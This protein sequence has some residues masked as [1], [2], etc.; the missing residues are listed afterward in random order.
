MKPK[1]LIFCLI[2]A[3]T[4]FSCGIE[5]PKRNVAIANIPEVID[6][7]KYVYGESETIRIERGVK[8]AASLWFSSDGTEEDFLKFCLKQFVPS[9]NDLDQLFN[10]VEKQFESINGHMREMSIQL[11][12]PVVTRQRKITEIDRLFGSSSPEFD[13]YKNKLAFAIALNFPHYTPEEKENY[14]KEW[15]RKEWAMARIGDKFDSRLNP[16]DAVDPLPLPDDLKDYTGLYILSMDHILSPGMEVLFPEGTRLNCHHGLRDEIKGLYTRED[17]LERQRMI[18]Q[19]VMHILDQTIPLCMIGETEFFWKPDSNEVFRKEGGKYVK[20]TFEEETDRRYR[21]LHNRFNARLREDAKFPEGSTWLKRTFENRQLS[22]ERI[23][24]ILESIVGAPE[25]RE[26]AKILE[27]RL[28]RKLEPFDIWYPGFQSQSKYDMNELDRIVREKYPSPLA[29]Q[30]DLPN[31]LKRIGFDNKTADFLGNHVIVDPVRS[32]GHANGPQMHGEK[33][34]LRTTFEPYGLNYKGFRIGMHET[35]HTIEQNVA[36]YYTDYYSLKGIPSAPFT[37]CM[38]DLIAYRDMVGLGVSREYSQEEKELNALASFMYVWEMGAEGIHEIRVWKWFYEHPDASVE[39]LREATL[40]IAGEIWNEYFAEFFGERDN[41][42]LSI[43]NHF[44]GGSLYL[45]A[46]PLGN[47]ILMQVEEYCKDKD[48]PS[49]MVR[50][51][52]IGKLT[53]DLWMQEATGE[54]VSAEPMLA[55]VRR[56]IENYYK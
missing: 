24:S 53:P 2:A 30:E 55:A 36:L 10:I 15:S 49:E 42:I 33:A 54:V 28:G 31:I 9:G 16:G 37:E 5:T 27:E 1:N 13:Y 51:C 29:F 34:H 39:E 17:P 46:Y 18:Y 11:D 50:M 6:S 41:T 45:H 8:H 44:L 12:Y 22:E 52:S 38:A 20:T 26:V 32:G 4:F 40:N 48:F 23:V 47:V 21:F 7:L 19:V 35:G 3:A 25:R 56:A 43:Y 14:G